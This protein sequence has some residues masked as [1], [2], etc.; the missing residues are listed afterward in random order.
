M[1]WRRVVRIF[2]RDVGYVAAALTV[3]FSISGIAV[4][5]IDDWNPN[6][7]VETDTLK[8]APIA[9]SILTAEKVRTYVVS[10]LNITDSIKSHFRPSPNEIDLFLE[11]KTI[12]ANVRTGLVSVETINNRKVF[13]KMNFL[14]LNTPKKLWTWV[15][16]IFAASLILLAI[17]GLFMIKGKKGFNGRGKWLFILGMLIP[18]FFLFIYY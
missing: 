6:Y 8:I 13:K 16:D 10:Q 9:D 17:T 1:K 11:R 12:S 7:V 5:H 4:N 18:I 3:I 2:H 15:S 14:H